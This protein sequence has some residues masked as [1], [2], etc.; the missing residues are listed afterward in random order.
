MLLV[1]GTIATHKTNDKYLFA[2]FR[3]AIYLIDCILLHFFPAHMVI[4]PVS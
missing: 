3:I 4:S 1:V 2:N